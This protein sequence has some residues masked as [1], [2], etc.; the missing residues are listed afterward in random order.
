[1]LNLTA[2]CDLL[3]ISH[4]EILW[5]ILV[6]CSA[7]ISKQ[8]ITNSLGIPMKANVIEEDPFENL[9]SWGENVN[10]INKAV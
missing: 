8:T 9:R 6:R 10:L 7:K 1:M 5:R 2:V 4:H 3:A